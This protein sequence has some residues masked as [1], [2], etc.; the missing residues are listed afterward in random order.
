MAVHVAFSASTPA[1][2]MAVQ[3]RYGCVATKPPQPVPQAQA[4]SP[5]LNYV[6]V[7]AP[8]SLSVTSN[9]RPRYDGWKFTSVEFS[10]TRIESPPQ[11]YL[12]YYPGGRE[13]KQVPFEDVKLISIGESK[14]HVEL[15]NGRIEEVRWFD[16]VVCGK[17]D[18]EG[19]VC[20]ADLK[21]RR[22]RGNER[23]VPALVPATS[24]QIE[25]LYFR[26]DQEQ[27]AYF[28]D[29]ERQRENRVREAQAAMERHVRTAQIGSVLEC[30]SSP[31]T[32]VVS[33][34]DVVHCNSDTMYSGTSKSLKMPQ[35]RAFGWRMESVRAG[36]NAVNNPEHV[37]VY[38][39]KIR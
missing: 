1:S 33:D 39:R 17:N 32:G 35:W 14:N 4:S 8:R 20:T 25:Y 9:G 26:S 13:T 16:A 22:E 30:W 5:P 34:F 6:S 21:V 12:R 23:A 19:K 29:L 2:R 27:A 38:L 10:D 36:V 7:P 28:A 3:G 37:G 31:R 24:R 11:L 18:R 15:R